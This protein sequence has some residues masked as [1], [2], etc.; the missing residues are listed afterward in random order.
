[1]H[2]DLEEDSGL[3]SSTHLGGLQP[4][5]TVGSHS[6]IHSDL[7]YTHKIKINNAL[8]RPSKQDK[9]KQ[10]KTKQ[11]KT[12]QRNNLDTSRAI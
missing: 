1:M 11:N 4:S 7:M 10:N 8:T 2:L 5:V 12:K 9:T 3:I 6:H